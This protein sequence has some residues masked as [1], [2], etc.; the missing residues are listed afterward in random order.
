MVSIKYNCD[1]VGCTTPCPALDEGDV[2]G[3]NTC[4]VGSLSCLCCKHNQFI[5]ATKQEVGCDN[6]RVCA[7]HADSPLHCR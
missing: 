4:M 1:A 6:P 5:D 2:R 3:R 7:D